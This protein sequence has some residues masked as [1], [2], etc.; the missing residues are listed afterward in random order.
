MKT[1]DLE[2]W[3][4]RRHFEVFRSLDFPHFSL[5]AEVDV[6]H[7]VASRPSIGMSL[8]IAIVYALARA[9]NEQ[10]DFRLRLR[11]GQVVEHEVIHPSPTVMGEGRLFSFCTIPYSP[12]PE[13]FAA[14]ASERMAQA[15]L[16]PRLED[17]PGQDDL[18]FMTSLPWVSFTSFTHPIHMRPVDSIP[19]LAWGKI[20]S[21]DGRQ[22]MPLSV[23]VHHALMDGVHVGQYYQAVQDLL[24]RA[25]EWP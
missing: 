12:E 11:E 22:V 14:C 16:A 13:A 7:L 23:Q 19:R 8:T 21:R 3:P 1:I 20:A 17:D 4:R 24:H 2:T 18:L 5:C 10:I 9:A 25:A 15:Q 6:T